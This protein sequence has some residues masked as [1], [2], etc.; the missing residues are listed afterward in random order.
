MNHDIRTLLG[1]SGVYSTSSI[2]TYYLSTF[3]APAKTSEKDE[4]AIVLKARGSS[5]N[6]HDSQ[7]KLPESPESGQLDRGL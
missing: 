2:L 7:P 5:L 1:Q 3:E 6:Q 4:E